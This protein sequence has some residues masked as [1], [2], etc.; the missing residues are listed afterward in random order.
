MPLTIDASLD[1]PLY[2]QIRDQ[3]RFQIASGSLKEGERLEPSRELAKRLGVHRTT[4]GNA[5][6]D[7]EAEGLISGTVGRGT[8]VTPLAVKLLAPPPPVARCATDVFWDSF[9]P[10]E[11]RDDALGRLM[12]SAS[13]PDVIS[14]ATAHGSDELVP[15]DLVRRVTDA[16]LRREG[17]RLFQYG[18]SDGYPA[19]KSYLLSRLRRDGV[20]AEPDEILITNGCQ[21]SLDLLRRSLVLNGDVVI[22]ENPTYT[23]LWHVFDSPGVRLIGVP[24]GAEGMDLDLVEAVLEQTKARLILASPNFQN[25]TGRTMPL[26]ERKRLLSLA[27]RFQVPVVEDDV[28][29]ALRYSGRE[30]PS[31]KALDTTGL[32]IHLNSFSKVGFGGLRIGWIVASRRLLER[33]RWTKQHADLHTNL[34]GQAVLEEFGRRGWLDRLIRR[35]RKVYERKLAILRRAA[36]RHFPESVQVVYPEGGMSVW[37]TLPAHLDASELLVKARDRRVIFA[38]AKYFYFQNPQH[39]ALRLCFTGVEDAQIGKGI[40]ILGDLLKAELRKSRGKKPASGLA[41]A[42]V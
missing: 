21:Q 14:F 4:V 19:L 38:P 41:V 40:A 33:L 13:A 35:A 11:Q 3:I 22:S 42:L 6:A 10:E 20:A 32:V 12:A 30:L 15:V 27:Q 26:M 5:Y 18:S 1:K 39:N 24:V 8:F 34:L 23:G 16:V 37:V 9:L 7:L 2:A 31:L 36:E 29:G 28:Y 17:T 25:P